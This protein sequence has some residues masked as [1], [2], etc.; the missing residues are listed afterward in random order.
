M[1]SSSATSNIIKKGLNTILNVILKL[2]VCLNWGFGTLTN[3]VREVG[4]SSVTSSIST[5]SA[6]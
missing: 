6:N 1:G 4:S 2:F 5:M 3:Q